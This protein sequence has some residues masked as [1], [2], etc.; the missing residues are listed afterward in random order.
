MEFIV[1]ALGMI[2]SVLLFVVGY[3]LGERSAR[4]VPQTIIERKPEIQTPVTKQ[5]PKAPANTSVNKNNSPVGG[6]RV[7][8]PREAIAAE[9]QK[10][11]GI[12]RTAPPE[13]I[14]VEVANE[15]M[16]EAGAVV[17]STAAK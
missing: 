6:L 16:Q 8:S 5:V 9:R 17:A 7:V 14:P 2:A 13:R 12:V 1:T 3:L 11:D 10:R 15:F 4:T